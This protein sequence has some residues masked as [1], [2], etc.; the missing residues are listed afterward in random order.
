MATIHHYLQGTKGTELSAAWW[1]A[2]AVIVSTA[3][4]AWLAIRFEVNEWFETWTSSRERYQLDELRG[5]V[6]V[7]VLALLW[8]A[9]RRYGA[10][11]AVLKQR[12]LVQMELVQSLQ[13]NSRL[14][15]QTMAAQEADR[16]HIARE[17]HDEMGQYLNAIKI[18]AVTLQ[19]QAAPAQ[20]QALAAIIRNTDHVYQVIG[21]MIKQLRPA[22]LDDLGLAV[23]LEN[24]IDEWRQRAPRIRFSLEI[25]GELVNLNEARTLAIY[26]IA[27]EG[28]TNALK[29][30]TPS[31]VTV[32]IERTDRTI[33]V[34]VRDDGVGTNPISNAGV[35]LGLIGMRE[36]LQ[37]LGGK[38]NAG[39]VSQ[40]MFELIAC[41]PADGEP[42]P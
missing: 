10:V 35:G 26:R 37:S 8:F 7:F 29:H 20:K 3:L 39:I 32:G 38:L 42:S 12:N 28:V 17:L 33:T 13:E 36:R 30:G 4:A 31:Q 25:R 21:T 22:G 41:F 27:Q 19:R 11:R 18:D 9:L 40:K 24:C 1:D 15:Q 14:T 34:A 6:V 16:K 5:V 2:A 23:A